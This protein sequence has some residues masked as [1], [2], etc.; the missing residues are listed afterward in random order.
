MMYKCICCGEIFDEPRNYV[1]SYGFGNLYVEHWSCC[2]Y[3]GG[4][5]IKNNEEE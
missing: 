5:Y 3:C 2:P 1:E 4:D